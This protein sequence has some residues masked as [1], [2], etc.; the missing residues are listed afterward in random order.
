MGAEAMHFTNAEGVRL[1]ALLNRPAG[2]PKGYALFAHCFTCGKDIPAARM[3]AE[4]LVAHG[5]AVLRFDFSG[6][7]GSGG[8][9]ANTNFSSQIDDLVAAADHLREIAEAPK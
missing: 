5:I 9:F 2:K 1:A 3:I 7:G 4:R 6:L 8:D